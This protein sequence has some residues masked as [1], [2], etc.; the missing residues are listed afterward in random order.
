M[1]IE[2]PKNTWTSKLS[3][4]EV[5]ISRIFCFLLELLVFIVVF[6]IFILYLKKLFTIACYI[7]R[8]LMSKNLD[9]TFFSNSICFLY[10]YQIIRIQ[11][12]V[13][14][15]TCRINS[16][17]FTVLFLHLTWTLRFHS[18]FEIRESHSGF[19]Y[20]YSKL[21]DS[22]LSFKNFRIFNNS[23]W[24]CERIQIIFS[25]NSILYMYHNPRQQ[26]FQQH[27]IYDIE[28]YFK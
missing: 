3:K 22:S 17:I 5:V 12:H 8:F 24:N 23:F 26:R 21:L 10:S 1:G 19:Y 7:F 4:V 27:R 25:Q 16:F 2:I 13:L 15:F 18:N 28:N 11:I 9:I 14:V 20:Y 6:I